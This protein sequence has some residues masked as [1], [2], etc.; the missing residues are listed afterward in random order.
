MEDDYII[1]CCNEKCCWSGLKSAT[2]TPKHDRDRA[3]GM[4]LCPECYE[5]CEPE[6]LIWGELAMKKAKKKIFKML[7]RAVGE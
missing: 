2:V 4:I 5:V 3:D 7:R 6:Q 1:T